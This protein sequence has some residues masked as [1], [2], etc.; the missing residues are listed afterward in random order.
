EYLA[1][2]FKAVDKGLHHILTNETAPLLV[3][4]VE[5]EIALYRRISTYPHLMDHAISGSPDGVRPGELHQRALEIVRQTFS[6]PL[7]KVFAEFEKHRKANR[8]SFSIETILAATYEG[9]VADFLLREDAEHRGICTWDETTQVHAGEGAAQ[10]EDLFNFAALQ[11][12]LHGGQAF[13]LKASE[14][15]D[16]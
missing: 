15:P 11:T 8:V 16:G 1:H 7:T 3:A 2:F 13:A 5:S 6:T 9:R 10:E 4:G 12:V 14:M